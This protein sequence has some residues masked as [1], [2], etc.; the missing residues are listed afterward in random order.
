LLPSS[1]VLSVAVTI[2]R[3]RHR[4]QLAQRCDTSD[5]GVTRVHR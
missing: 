5:A 4:C 2:R 3:M 1:A